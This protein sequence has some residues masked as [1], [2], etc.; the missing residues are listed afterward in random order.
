[1]KRRLFI[2]PALLCLVTTVF[3]Q[4]NTYKYGVVPPEQLNMKH[5]EKDSIAK[6]VV[7]YEYGDSSIKRNRY[8]DIRLIYTYKARVKIFKKEAFHKSPIEIDPKLTRT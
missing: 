7:L 2:L 4:N 1:M 3:A 6:A 8:G 5:Y